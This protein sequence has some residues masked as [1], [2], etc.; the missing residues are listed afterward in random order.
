MSATEQPPLKR[1]RTSEESSARAEQFGPQLVR[2]EDL[3]FEDGSAIIQ[4]ESTQF[5]VHKTVLARLSSIFC[6]VLQL[7]EQSASEAVVDEC[8]VVHVSDS[9]VEMHQL[10]RLLYDLKYGQDELPTFTQIA[11]M[12]RL[13]RKYGVEPLYQESLRMNRR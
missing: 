7:G 11:A 2:S 3:C 1:P 13:E 4:A 10:L 12:L 8:L 9:A 5:R 6:H